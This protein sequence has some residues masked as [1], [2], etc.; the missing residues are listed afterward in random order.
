VVTGLVPTDLDAQDCR[1]PFLK[2][3]LRLDDGTPN[4]RTPQVVA[5]RTGHTGT[6]FFEFRF[7]S[8]RASVSRFA[9]PI[10][11]DSLLLRL[12]KSLNAR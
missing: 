6:S 3:L 11:V 5:G 12:H 1:I 8:L 9:L 2:N 7:H 4:E 10:A